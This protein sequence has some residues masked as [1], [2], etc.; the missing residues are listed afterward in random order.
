MLFALIRNVALCLLLTSPAWADQSVSV[1]RAA[2]EHDIKTLCPKQYRQ[3]SLLLICYC[4][5]RNSPRISSKCKSAWHAE[6][7]MLG[8]SKCP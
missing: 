6:Y 4:M 2:C 8:A 5:E 7:G 1:V 3:A